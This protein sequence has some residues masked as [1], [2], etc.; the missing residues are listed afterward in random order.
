[1]SSSIPKQPPT[2]LGRTLQSVP[3]TSVGGADIVRGKKPAAGAEPAP[4]AS[5][6][7][8]A[9]VK[10]RDGT[11]PVPEIGLSWMTPRERVHH[12]GLY[13]G[14]VQLAAEET[15]LNLPLAERLPVAD[16]EARPR[17]A[18]SAEWVA[19]AKPAELT[20][21]DDV[22][23]SGNNY[24]ITFKVYDPTDA[25][26]V[27]FGLSHVG[28]GDFVVL[29]AHDPYVSRGHFTVEHKTVAEGLRTIEALEKRLAQ[30][31]DPRMGGKLEAQAAGTEKQLNQVKGELLRAMP[32]LF[33]EEVARALNPR[34][35]AAEVATPVA[36]APVA[37]APIAA[38]K[39]SAP[40]AQ[41]TSA[42][43]PE[44]GFD[45]TYNPPRVEVR[46][47]TL[48]R[49]DGSVVLFGNAEHIAAKFIGPQNLPIARRLQH[50]AQ[51]EADKLIAQGVDPEKIHIV[52]D[53]ERIL[54]PGVVP[55]A[56]SRYRPITG[57]E[58]D[59]PFT[60]D[61]FGWNTTHHD[62]VRMKG[63]LTTRDQKRE[64]QI[65]AEDVKGTRVSYGDQ[66]LSLGRMMR[67]VAT[68]ELGVGDVEQ[69]LLFD[70]S[71]DKGRSF[72]P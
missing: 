15:K 63:K 69:V 32:A 25:R 7:P 22:S 8:L 27:G 50:V 37:G 45:T 18:R 30:Q 33:G 3:K 41:I 55:K 17:M 21:I 70:Q 64:L 56:F 2:P 71:T 51:L 24:Q 39:P 67:M 68:H 28:G 1:M 6:P 20:L 9:P 29:T 34:R 48:A 40:Q 72:T 23:M 10:K 38:A 13:E 12:R 49:P 66:Q 11:T 59:K 26:E 65:W 14:W 5:L 54:D 43:H 60:F 44:W 31:R 16:H 47:T 46:I 4:A 61:G 36:A 62:G 58:R 42:I 52:I 57:V 35:K 53:A 19:Q